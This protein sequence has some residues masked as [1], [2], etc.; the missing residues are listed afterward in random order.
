MLLFISK[1][2][3]VNGAGG[4]GGG[5]GARHHRNLLKDMGKEKGREGKH[6]QEVANSEPSKPMALSFLPNYKI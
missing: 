6:T 3:I 5:G 2:S 4:S 1:N